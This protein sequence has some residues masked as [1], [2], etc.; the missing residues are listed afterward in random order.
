LTKKFYRLNQ[1]ITAPTVRVVDEQGKQI[2][3]LPISEALKKAAEL[4]ADLV[5]VA[6]SANPPVCKIIDFKKFKYL[7][8][9]KHQEEKRKSKKV[10]IKEVRLTPFIA[11]NDFDFRIKRAEEFLKEG[12][13]VKISVKFHGRQLTRKEFGYEL[14]AKAKEKLAFCSKLE[15]EPKFVGNQLE[16]LL[17]PLK[18]QKHEQNQNENK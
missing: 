5:E 13:K 10:E 11:K 9:K 12:N 8:A 16:M 1:Y 4:N 2:G 6:P 14:I 15:G 3:I 7:E 17:S 18:E